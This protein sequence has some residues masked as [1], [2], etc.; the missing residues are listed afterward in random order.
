MQEKAIETIL[1]S[2][3]GVVAMLAILVAVNFIVG[4]APKRIDLTQEK[5]YTLSDGTKAILKKLD[6]PVKIRFYFSQGETANPQTVF[7]K[8][9]AKRVEDLLGEYKQA[10]KGKI[11]IEKFDPEPDSDAED[12]ARMD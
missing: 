4:L 3:A 2:A 10:G 12:S 7:L 6:T 9:Y 11:I 1:Y 8:A 5:A